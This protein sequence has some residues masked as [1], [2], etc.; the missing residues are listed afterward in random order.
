MKVSTVAVFIVFALVN[1][2]AGPIFSDSV[3][4]V[5]NLADKNGDGKIDLDE[6]KA[7][8]EKLGLSG[9]KLDSMALV[10]LR[11]LDL[12]EDGFVTLDELRTVSDPAAFFKTID[13]D[14]DGKVNFD[15]FKAF[16][17]RVYPD[18]LPGVG[19]EDL[20]QVFDKTDTDKDGF[21]TQE[22]ILASYQPGIQSLLERILS[23]NKK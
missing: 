13:K 4:D 8:L 1:V 17:Q 16:F 15:E 9:E 20:R 22:E 19:P 14:G 12:N 2:S 10:F 5:F 21:L 7:A 6:I 18:G 23:A 11:T 3:E